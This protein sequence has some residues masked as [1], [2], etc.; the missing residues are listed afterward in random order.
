MYFF[1]Q[2]SA[3]K[4]FYKSQHASQVILWDRK[5]LPGVWY[6]TLQRQFTMSYPTGSGSVNHIMIRLADLPQRAVLH[7]LSVN[8]KNKD[9][10]FACHANTI[11]QDSR[12][13]YV[14]I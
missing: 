5:S 1:K 8:H 13:W 10:L 6:Q 7:V 9:W 3:G 14:F 12:L 2:R 4:N 11:Y